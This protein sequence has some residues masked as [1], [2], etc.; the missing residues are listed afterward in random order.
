MSLCWVSWHPEKTV[1]AYFSVEWG[2]EK[3]KRFWF[4]WHLFISL[5]TMNVAPP[6]FEWLPTDF[7]C[8]VL[9]A[10]GPGDAGP[11]STTGPE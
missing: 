8:N 7:R 5:A 10:A 3:K 6:P 1:L 11:I 4:R 2:T 9:T